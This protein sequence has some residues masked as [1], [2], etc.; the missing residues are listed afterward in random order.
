MEV[1]LEESLCPL[2]GGGSLEKGLSEKRVQLSTK[3]K[4]GNKP[5]PEEPPEKE[6]LEFKL[7]RNRKGKSSN[8]R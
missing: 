4:K 3:R 2:I 1:L 5:V 6:S 7:Q 8:I